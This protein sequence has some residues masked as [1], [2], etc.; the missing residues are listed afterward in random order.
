MKTIKVPG[1]DQINIES[2]ELLQQV[3]EKIGKIPN[4]YATIGYASSALKSMLNTE[5]LLAHGS[6]FSA[7]ECE[8]I[9]LIVS[10]VNECAYCL[11]AHTLTAKMQGYTSEDIIAIRKA[12]YGDAK[13]NSLIRLAQSI[14]ANAGKADQ[15]VLS[16]F[17]ENGY[18]EKALIELIALVTLRSFTNYVYVN[19][20]IP[21]D[22]PKA[23]DLV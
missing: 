4:L 20:Q 21:I 12:E 1:L 7:K 19:T 3:Q 6:S 2:K 15:E 13:V 11:A 8:A 22:F 5:S 10:Q 23:A 16:A 18:D 9:N 14:T 17:F